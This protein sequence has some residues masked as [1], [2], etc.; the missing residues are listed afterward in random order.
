RRAGTTPYRH[1]DRMMLDSALPD[2]RAAA[3]IAKASMDAELRGMERLLRHRGETIVRLDSRGRALPGQ[4]MGEADP[5][6][7]L[8]IVGR[9]LT[10]TNPASQPM[11][12][13]AVD[14]A[15]QPPGAITLVSLTAPD[16]RRYILQIH[17][18]LGRTR[19]IFLS[20]TALGVLI[21]REPAPAAVR[22]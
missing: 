2:L 20:A 14:T 15:L 12:D 17:P 21:E 8:R 13:T 9:R 18:L 11:L 19:D 1:A 7:P 3:R 4:A 6:S 5:V 22:Q 16:G 10:A